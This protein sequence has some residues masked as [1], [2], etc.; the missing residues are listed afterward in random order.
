MI[1]SR[2]RSRYLISSP[3]KTSPHYLNRQA[4]EAAAKRNQHMKAPLYL[5]TKT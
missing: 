5:P 4:R 2:R 1:G 3:V